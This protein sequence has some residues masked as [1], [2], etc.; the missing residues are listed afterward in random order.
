[1]DVLGGILR[2]CAL[3]FSFLVLLQLKSYKASFQPNES[4]PKPKGNS[5]GAPLKKILYFT[6]FF[7]HKDWQF[8]FGSNPFLLAGCPQSKCFVTNQGNPENF[9]AL[10]FHS[11]YSSNMVKGVKKKLKVSENVCSSLFC[12]GS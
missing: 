7:T 12:S 3:L 2:V 11:F 9:D 10:L 1:M 5:N 6:P 4:K 8:G